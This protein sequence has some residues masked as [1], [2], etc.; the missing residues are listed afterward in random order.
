MPNVSIWKMQR[1]KPMYMKELTEWF[2][3]NNLI[4]A[5]GETI[6]IPIEST[7]FKVEMKHSGTGYWKVT[8]RY[9]D[10]EINEISVHC[11]EVA[12]PFE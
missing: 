10:P 5:I 7:A 11:T 6:I 8:M 9:Y 12:N 3:K 4:P 2:N 1:G